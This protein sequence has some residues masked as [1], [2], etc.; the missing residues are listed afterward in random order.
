MATFLKVTLM[1]MVEDA[2]WYGAGR[3]GNM[4]TWVVVIIWVVVAVVFTKW[5]RR[6]K[7]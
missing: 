4:P 7:T 1:M 3:F 6:G 2:M 5:I